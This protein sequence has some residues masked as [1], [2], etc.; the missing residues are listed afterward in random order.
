MGKEHYISEANRQLSDTTYYKRL[1][2]RSRPNVWPPETGAEMITSKE[3]SDDNVEYLTVENPSAGRF[4]LLPKIYKPSNP[5]LPIV[6]ANGHPTKPI[7][8]FVDLHHL[9]LY[10][11]R[12]SKI[13]H[14][15]PSNSKRHIQRDIAYL[16]WCCVFIHQHTKWRRHRGMQRGEEH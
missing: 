14:I 12:M 3:I 8:E 5:G 15:L 11:H 16:T 6:S 7:S 4:Y 10:Y 13:P 1:D 2:H 9:S